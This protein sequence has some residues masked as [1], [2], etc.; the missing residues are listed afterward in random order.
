M[1]SVKS[2]MSGGGGGEGTAKNV[3][4]SETREHPDRERLNVTPQ[5]GGKE[6]KQTPE[7]E[8]NKKGWKN[9]K[10]K[11]R[12]EWKIQ[13]VSHKS[14]IRGIRVLKRR[15][16]L[17]NLWLQFFQVD[18]AID[19]GDKKKRLFFKRACRNPPPPLIIQGYMYAGLNPHPGCPLTQLPCF[20]SRH[21]PVTP[22]FGVA[23]PWMSPVWTSAPAFT[24]RQNGSWLIQFKAIRK[25]QYKAN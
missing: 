22:S 18:C 3:H 7:G 11:G 19:A 9:E 24:L 15:I 13:F 8:K 20:T 5:R 17:N 14:S 16:T 25:A 21:S 10:N 1:Y 12:T 6:E 4:W 2:S 23:R